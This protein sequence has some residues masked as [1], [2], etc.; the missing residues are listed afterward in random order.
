MEYAAGGELYEYLDA[1]PSGVSDEEAKRFFR[2][3]V[4]AVRYCHNVSAVIL[5]NDVSKLISNI[6][7]KEQLKVHAWTF[8]FTSGTIVN[9]VNLC[10]VA[11]HESFYL[12]LI[13]TIRY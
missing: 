8:G 3:I 6:T 5:R 1:R 13:C 12:F 7:A 9:A 10:C 11:L 4:S 2:Q